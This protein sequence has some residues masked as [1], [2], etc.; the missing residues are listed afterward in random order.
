[1]DLRDFPM[2][3][4]TCNLVFGSYGYTDN[5]IK[6]SWKSTK[7]LIANKEMAQFSLGDCVL[8]LKTMEYVQG[9]YTL[10]SAS[11]PMHRRIGYYAI[12]MYVPC[13]FLVML[14]WIVFWMNP[15]ETGNR[16]TVGITTILTIVFLLGYTNSTLPKVSYV[17][18]MDWYLMVSFLFI[19][20][21]L[22]E[23][24]VVDRAC[25]HAKLDTRKKSKK[26]NGKKQQQ[27]NQQPKQQQQQLQR[28]KMEQLNELQSAR[29]E[30]LTLFEPNCNDFLPEGRIVQTK[31]WVES[32]VE[33]H[34]KDREGTR[35]KCCP[36]CAHSTTNRVD[37]CS[38]L[39]FP[40][41]FILY[42]VLYWYSYKYGVA[43]F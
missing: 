39:A 22:C 40:F 3:T 32:P 28:E 6:L 15:E 14:S 27:L 43:I 35:N 2:D 9:N 34:S 1:M 38:R 21:S 7:I 8:S 42:N 24:I 33:Q 18:G 41:L 12:Q 13:T 30:N 19:F 10:L 37:Q 4:Q 23:C 25:K 16:L 36:T 26:S 11:F 31:T 5:D 20:L 17:K 29:I